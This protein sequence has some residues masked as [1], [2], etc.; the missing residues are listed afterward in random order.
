MSLAGGVDT[1][2]LPNAPGFC[3]PDG[4]L[5]F[6]LLLALIIALIDKKNRP[7]KHADIR[8]PDGKIWALS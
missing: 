3:H 6:V 8:H 2:G 1:A 7:S 5:G 4:S